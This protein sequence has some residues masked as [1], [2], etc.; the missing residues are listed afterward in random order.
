MSA[1]P[2]VQEQSEESQGHLQEAPQHNGYKPAPRGKRIFAALIDA[3]IGGSING[4]LLYLFAKMQLPYGAIISGIFVMGAYY[5]FPTFA[6]GQTL[7]KKL[8]GIMVV[9]NDPRQEEHN[10]LFILLRESVFKYIS[11]IPIGLGYLWF[12]FND[13]HKTWHDMLGGTKVVEAE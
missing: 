3:V 9:P 2:Q 8:M 7:G 13:E 10:F 5:I 12:F 1:Q 11:A 4:G 6:L